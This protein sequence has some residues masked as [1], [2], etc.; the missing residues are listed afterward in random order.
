VT[1]PPE[2]PP[3]WHKQPEE[4]DVAFGAFVVYR[5]LPPNERSAV[6][7]ASEY[8]RSASLIERW[9]ARWFWV[10]RA[11]AYDAHQAEEHRKAQLAERGK[12]SERQAAEA[13][14]IQRVLFAPVRA[15]AIKLADLI[16]REE[17]DNL[18]VAELYAMS[19]A[20]AR[21]W[22]AVARAE[23]EARGAPV[24]EFVPPD[25]TPEGL[26]DGGLVLTEEFLAEVHL[27]L[28]AA[29]L[30]PRQLA[31]GDDAIDVTPTEEAE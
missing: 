3:L 6:R 2:L 28:E 4:T 16:D 27:A 21:L 12:M 13:Q 20:T 8:G 24:P 7:V 10:E 25:E 18:T 17:L 1:P 22:P 15:L 23:R 26:P 19:L 14:V 9:R 30:P 11:R 31:A 5:D 29:N